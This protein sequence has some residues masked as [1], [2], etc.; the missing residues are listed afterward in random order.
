LRR[1]N[2]GLVIIAIYKWLTAALC[3]VLAFGLLRLLHQDV[4]EAAERF[5]RSAGVDADN[6]MVERL[7]ARLSLIEDPQ[8]AKLS[9]AS[10][11]Y[12]ALF[13]V[14]GT[15]LFFEKRWAEYLTIIATASFLPFEGYAIVHKVEAFRILVL[16]INVAVLVFLVITIRKNQTSA[17]KRS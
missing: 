1:H 12:C 10:F 7:L 9:A 13:L 16:L 15:G 5:I 2:R 8:L 17:A 11:G 6:H 3:A 14:E 4:G